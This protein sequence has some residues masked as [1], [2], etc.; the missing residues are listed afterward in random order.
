M[1][2]LITEAIDASAIQML[3]TAGHDVEK[4]FYAPRDEIMAA[5]EDADAAIIRSR[6][7]MDRELLDAGKKLLVV[8]VH[9]SGTDHVDKTYAKERGIAVLNVADGNSDSVT[10]LT[11]G[12]MLNL[13]RRIGEAAADVRRGGWR[14]DDFV[15]RELF[16]KTIGVIGLGSI[17][18]RVAAVAAALGM[19]PVGFDPYLKDPSAAGYPVV[20]DLGELLSQSDVVSVHIPLT[21]E[22]KGLINLSHLPLLRDGV[23]L[24]NCARGG[25]IADDLL[26]AGLR[27]G[28]IAGYGADV[29]PEEPPER[30]H[31]LLQYPNVIITP[32]FGARTV[33][34]QRKVAQSI[35]QKVLSALENCKA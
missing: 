3:E 22:T 35:A 27:S 11:I 18:R 9:G 14:A 24:L 29:M 2:I 26:L 21:D 16:G 28:K 1:K 5:M 19:K 33:E 20:S 13:S 6:T 34:A 15:G 7:K 10:E 4:R 32:H 31:P 23:I 25:I 17:G 8:G 30:G 12:L